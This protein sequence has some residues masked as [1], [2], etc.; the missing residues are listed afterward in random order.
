MWP[1]RQCLCACCSLR[2][3]LEVLRAKKVFAACIYLQGG[4]SDGASAP[5]AHDLVL[6]D[7]VASRRDLASAYR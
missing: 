6:C 2:F 7:A 4:L 1:E 3:A 5:V